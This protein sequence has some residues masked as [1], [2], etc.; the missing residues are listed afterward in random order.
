[1]T[2]LEKKE[3]FLQLIH[4]TTWNVPEEYSV[5]IKHV[6]FDFEDI[7]EE[8]F[9]MNLFPNQI[10]RFIQ[11][12]FESIFSVANVLNSYAII[13][14]MHGAPVVSITLNN[15]KDESR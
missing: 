1:M 13:K 7:H 10:N 12:E 15:D 5:S 6:K 11:D 14:V 3:L 8:F 9:T 4:R 2:A